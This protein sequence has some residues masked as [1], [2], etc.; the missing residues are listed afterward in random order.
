MNPTVSSLLSLAL[1]LFIAV[2]ISTA[3]SI[4]DETQGGSA[5]ALDDE[6]QPADYRSVLKLVKYEILIKMMNDLCDE[7]DMCQPSQVPARQPSIVRRGENNERR[8]GGSHL[9][10]RTALLKNPA[11]KTAN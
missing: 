7:L 9:F 11:L 3:L 6:E 5:W 1:L 10:W 2:Q 4:S 8:R